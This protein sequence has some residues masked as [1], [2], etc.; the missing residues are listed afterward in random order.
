ML[1]S[2][3]GGFQAFGN[4]RPGLSE[5]PA[6]NHTAERADFCVCSCTDATD[7]TVERTEFC[8]CMCTDDAAAT[9]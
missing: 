2:N 6:A 3:Q 8:L 7:N 5:T 9:R 4:A 1:N